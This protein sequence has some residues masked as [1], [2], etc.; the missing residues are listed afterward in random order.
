LIGTDLR[1]R[2]LAAFGDDVLRLLVPHTS[3]ITLSV[4]RIVSEPGD[5]IV[6]V[7][8]PTS[9]VISIVTVLEDGSRVESLTV[10]REGAVGLL[11]CFGDGRSANRGV[12][13][14][15]GAALRIDARSLRTTAQDHPLITDVVLRYAQATEAQLHQAAACNA[16]HSIEARLC[17]WLL[18]CEDRVGDDVL[19]LTQEFLAMMLGV[20][21]TSV[22]MAAQALQRRGL[23]KYR[24]GHIT[25][26]D[27]RGMEQTSCECYGTLRS[28]Y[29]RIFP[30]SADAAK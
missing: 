12:V 9:G 16:M 23:I 11:A 21:R 6:N 4:G 2:L 28:V 1:N 22:T 27:R 3:E 25:V 13:Q 14:I 15:A 5:L 18:T 10:G 20:Q 19:P 17:R 8:F 7:F 26:L 30:S 29:D 24:R